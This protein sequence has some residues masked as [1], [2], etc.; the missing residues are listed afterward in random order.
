MTPEVTERAMPATPEVA[1]GAMSAAPM[2]T[3]VSAPMSASGF[4]G[5]R[6][7]GPHANRQDRSETERQQ[8]SNFI[9]RKHGSPLIVKN[10]F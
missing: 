6:E 7:R 3:A 10:V 5:A 2:P 4:R 8:P 9:G 1:E